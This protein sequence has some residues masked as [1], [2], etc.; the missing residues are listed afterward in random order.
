MV[1]RKY[2]IRNKTRTAA[3]NKDACERCKQCKHERRMRPSGGSRQR[4]R[5]KLQTEL[6]RLGLHVARHFGSS[7]AQWCRFKRATNSL[8]EISISIIVT[9]SPSC[10]NTSFVLIF[11]SNVPFRPLPRGILSSQLPLSSLPYTHSV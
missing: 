4:L 11:F 1:D 3:N 10:R 9:A 5:L 8:L 2:A 6:F 7:H